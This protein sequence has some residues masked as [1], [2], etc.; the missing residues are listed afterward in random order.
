[1]K[2][3]EVRETT[4][5]DGLV[6]NSSRAD[7]RPAPGEILVRMRAAALNYRDQGVIKG[8]YGYTKFPLIP[9]SDGAGEVVA[10][11]DAVTQFKPGDRVTST[12]FVNWTG[13]R[14][15]ADASRNS[16]GGMVSGVLAEYALL[17]ESG[18]IRIA[19]NLSFEDAAT[20]PC[21]ALTAWN[22]VVE[23]GQIKAGETIALL[24]TGGVSCFALAFAKMHGAYAFL[25]SSNEEKLARAK[26]LGADALINYRSWPEWDQ[27]ILKQTGGAG[28][29]LVIEVGGA[30]TLERS[31]NAVRPGGT[32]CVIGALAGAGAINPRMINRKSIRLQGIHVGSREMFDSMN[33][34][35]ALHRLKPAIDKIFSFSD[36]K[37]AYLHQQSGKHFGKIVISVAN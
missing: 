14:M 4:G 5:L 28:V 25:S 31:M 1:M 33:R 35:V 19:A 16:L 32:I 8:A 2:A 36:A 11:G 24:G 13:G 30:G 7:P 12:F 22:A 15:P 17:Q 34:A 3:Y 37:A 26:T 10:A 27:E 9:L 21:A 20:L 29:D 6:L 23:T 18:A